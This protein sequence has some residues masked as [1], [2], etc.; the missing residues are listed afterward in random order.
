MQTVIYALFHLAPCTPNQISVWDEA[1]HHHLLTATTNWICDL[2]K[3]LMNCCFTVTMVNS[4]FLSGSSKGL[5]VMGQLSTSSTGEKIIPPP[6][7]ASNSK[8]PLV[9]QCGKNHQGMEIVSK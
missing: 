3:H 6:T 5:L 9:A 8:I 2:V 4:W 7:C 1:C